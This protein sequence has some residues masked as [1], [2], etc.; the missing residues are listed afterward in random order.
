M[1]RTWP[2]SK[3]DIDLRIGVD[4]KAKHG[5]IVDVRDFVPLS[6]LTGQLCGAVSS[7]FTPL[8][9]I[10]PTASTENGGGLSREDPNAFDSGVI[11]AG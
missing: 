11:V 6:P 5:L 9:L 2:S 4:G 8:K 3:R 10:G 1:Q 7:G